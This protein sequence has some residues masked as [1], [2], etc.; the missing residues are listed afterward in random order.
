MAEPVCFK[1]PKLSKDEVLALQAVWDGN[2]DPFQQRL[3]LGVI[4]NKFSRPNDL[5][6]VPGEPDQTTFLNGRAFT[7]MQVL[8]ILN[9]NVGQLQ[10]DGDTHE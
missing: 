3:A 4:C 9:I 7:G 10:D 5:L 1:V 2:A 8:K 6:Y